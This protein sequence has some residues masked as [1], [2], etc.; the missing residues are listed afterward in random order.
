MS[1][2]D[3]ITDVE[4]LGLNLGI[5]MS[6]LKRITISYPLMEKQK[7]KVIYYWLQRRDI[8]RHKQNEHPHG[9]DLLMLC[10]CSI[11]D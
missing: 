2:L 11:P 10:I 5:R 3:D 6:A 7:K 1:V 8:V 4:N 9:V